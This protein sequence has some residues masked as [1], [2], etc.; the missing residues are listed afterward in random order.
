VALSWFES[1]EV[2]A[3]RGRYSITEPMSAACHPVLTFITEE[4]ET[5][6]IARS[7]IR[8]V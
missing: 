5:V 2:A 1:V 7:L 6:E 3:R 4:G 8:P